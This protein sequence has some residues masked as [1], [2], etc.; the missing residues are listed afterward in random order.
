MMLYFWCDPGHH[1]IRTT[2][3]VDE[4]ESVSIYCPQHKFEMRLL[5]VGHEGRK[6]WLNLQNQKKEKSK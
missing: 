2:A 3:K 5:G 1:R 6:K 4:W